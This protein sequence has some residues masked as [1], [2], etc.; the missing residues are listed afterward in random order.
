MPIPLTDELAALVRVA[1]D[2]H[3]GNRRIYHCVPVRSRGIPAYM[4]PL[5]LRDYPAYGVTTPALF[6]YGPIITLRHSHGERHR[7]DDRHAHQLDAAGWTTY[8]QR[9]IYGLDGEVEPGITA[10]LSHVITSTQQWWAGRWSQRPVTV[11]VLDGAYWYLWTPHS[12]YD[13]GIYYRLDGVVRCLAQD[14][15][16]AYW[17]HASWSEWPCEYD[18][19][20]RFPTQC[21]AREQDWRSCDA[22]YPHAPITTMHP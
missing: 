10:S 2:P 13:E 14:G 22:E 18:V 21:E 19:A 9:D 4:G 5:L 16:T 15:D 3:R 20:S 1:T 6:R 8:Q 7:F 11:Y 12:T 17:H